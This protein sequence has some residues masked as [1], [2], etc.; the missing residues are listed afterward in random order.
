MNS[1]IGSIASLKET[2]YGSLVFLVL[3]IAIAYFEYYKLK[4]IKIA[5]EYSIVLTTSSG[6]TAAFASKDSKY[7]EDVEKALVNAI[8]FR[9]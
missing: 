6:E 7:I 3:S 4:S 8:V 1:P 5:Y 9:G 2:N